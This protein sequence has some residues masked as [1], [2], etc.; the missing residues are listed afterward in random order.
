[1]TQLLNFINENPTDWKMKIKKELKINVKENENYTLLMYETKADFT[2]PIVQECRG[3]ILNKENR[4][5]CCPFYKFGNFYEKYV[6]DIDWSSAR[7]EEKLDGSI[8]KFWF[9]NIWH[10]SSNTQIEIELPFTVDTSEFNK[11]YTYIFELIGK[12]NR[13]KI[14]YLKNE[15]VHI[16]VRNNKTFEELN[17]KLTDFGQPRI[18]DLHSVDECNEYLNNTKE[19]LEGF[20]VVDKNWN[21]LKIKSKRYLNSSIPSKKDIVKKILNDEQFDDYPENFFD[22]EKTKIQKLIE[23]LP[24]HKAFKFRR[25]KSLNE[26]EWLVNNVNYVLKFI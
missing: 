19:F 10:I 14:P 18:F 5:V 22:D 24:N 17:I 21:R 2:N 15:L 9:D 20:V 1:M 16:G 8:V 3:I 12:N 25:D 7:V 6:P 23:D 11:D 13:V 26:K 4:I